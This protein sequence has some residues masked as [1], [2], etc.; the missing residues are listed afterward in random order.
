MLLVLRAEPTVVGTAITSLAAEGEGDGARL[1]V[2]SVAHVGVGIGVDERLELAV[3]RAPLTQEDLAVA[4][5]DV[6][7]DGPPTVGT[8][9]SRELEEDVVRIVLDGGGSRR[10]HMLHRRTGIRLSGID[11]AVTGSTPTVMATQPS[12]WMR[13]PCQ[14]ATRLLI[15]AA[16]ALGSG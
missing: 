15:P 3:L 13:T 11:S 2:A 7:I 10:L 6:R 14:K 4:E 9:A 16:A 12:C 1:V 5:Q 8:D